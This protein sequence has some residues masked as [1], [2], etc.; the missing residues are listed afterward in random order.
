MSEVKQQ[1]PII[2]R[3]TTVLDAL[4]DL[5]E[6]IEALTI[7]LTPYLLPETNIKNEAKEVVKEAENPISPLE[8]YLIH[9]LNKIDDLKITIKQL[10]N[11]IR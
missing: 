8:E 11:R 1:R 5:R 10:D 4:D 2:E 6:S 9:S 7:K 3:A